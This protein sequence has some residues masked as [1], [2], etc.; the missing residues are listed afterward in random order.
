MSY[1]KKVFS[2]MMLVAAGFFLTCCGGGDDGQNPAPTAIGLSP[3]DNATGVAVDTNL[4]MTFSEEVFADG[5]SVT[6]KRS[7]D[8]LTVEVVDVPGDRVTGSGTHTITIDPLSDLAFGTGYY[9]LVSETAFDDKFGRNYEGIDDTGTWD[10]TTVEGSAKLQVISGYTYYRGDAADLQLFKDAIKNGYN[11]INICFACLNGKGE[12]SFDTEWHG[13]ISETALQ[14]AVENNTKVYLAF[15]GAY[16]CDFVLTENNN[17]A[18]LIVDQLN[19][20]CNDHGICY[21]GVNFDLEQSSII[22]QRTDQAFT[23]IV[24]IAQTLRESGYEVVIAP[25]YPYVIPVTNYNGQEPNTPAFYY[26]PNIYTKLLDAGLVDYV[27]VQLYNQPGGSEYSEALSY[28]CRDSVD[29]DPK[30]DPIVYEND[31]GFIKSFYANMIRY[32]KESIDLTDKLILGFPSSDGAYGRDPHWFGM[33]YAPQIAAELKTLSPFPK[34]VAVWAINN[35]AQADGSWPSDKQWHSVDAD[36]KTFYDK[37]PWD[38][39]KKIQQ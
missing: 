36:D 34:G 13:N 3:A 26:G 4:V 24:N 2:F 15:G 35:D 27:F 25:E 28:I 11:S 21:D 10:F 12:F 9:V 37:T 20:L 8:N 33:D 38:F 1:K 18:K 19:A 32:W 6:I 14:I 22:N 39:V 30:V 5:G 17:P 31:I 7:V 29:C 16:G 23:N